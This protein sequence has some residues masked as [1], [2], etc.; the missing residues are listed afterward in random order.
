[1]ATYRKRGSR[2]QAI[3]RIN[4]IAESRC[5][6]TKGEAK[7]WAEA[8]ERLITNATDEFM[9][10]AINYRV[11]D[12][13]D[14]YI[15]NHLPLTN[16]P[17]KMCETMKQKRE[18]A[19][20]R[21]RLNYLTL[22]KQHIGTERLQELNHVKL[23]LLR[24]KLR[25]YTDVRYGRKKEVRRSNSTLNR[26]MSHI[27]AVLQ[28]CVDEWKWLSDNPCSRLKMLNEP[29][30][31]TRFLDPKA[32]YRLL[33]E[34]SNT[35]ALRPIRCYIIIATNTGMR[36][37]EI[38]NLEWKNVNLERREIILRA[39]QTKT[40]MP[41]VVPLRDD[42]IDALR[43]MQSTSHPDDKYVFQS[44]QPNGRK[45]G[46]LMEL[47]KAFRQL[48][49]QAGIANFKGHDMRHTF[50]SYLAQA[51]E[52]LL[53][54]ADLCGHAD[55]ETTRRYAHLTKGHLHESVKKL[56]KILSSE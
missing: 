33:L 34:A 49:K 42:A 56:D 28:K 15:A 20:Q 32:E 46:H 8:R 50:A 5:F 19:F 2:H 39:D 31:R 25:V 47:R 51:G 11:S 23:G 26:A 12:A 18:R 10:E 37:G 55:I 6:D 14:R 3:V 38:R 54:I 45:K 48:V 29:K 52:S 53:S 22:F 9:L 16:I 4:G 30:G 36:F 7:A 40:E 17:A 35:P 43:E 21:S 44:R 1:M 27:S 13:I 24:D 41:R